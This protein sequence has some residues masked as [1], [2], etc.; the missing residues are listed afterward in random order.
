MQCKGNGEISI[1]SI[2]EIFMA[3][4]RKPSFSDALL[5]ASML[6]PERLV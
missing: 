6:V 3:V 1:K 4:G 5:S 2:K